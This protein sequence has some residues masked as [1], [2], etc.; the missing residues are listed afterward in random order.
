MNDVTRL[1]AVAAP[2]GTAVPYTERDAFELSLRQ[3]KVY[4]SADLVPQ[5][6][7]DNIP[8]CLIALNMARRIGSD[9]LQTMQS[10]Y[11]VQGKPGWSGQ[12]LIATFNQCGKFS[13]IRYQWK[14]EAGS[15][16]WGCRAYATEKATGDSIEGPWVT[17]KMV[18]AEGWN[19]KAG[20]KWLTMPEIMFSYRAAAFLVRTHAPEIAM[21]LAT[22]EE[23]RDVI[24][25]EPQPAKSATDAVLST[26]RGR[27]DKEAPHIDQE[28][29]TGPVPANLPPAVEVPQEAPPPFALDPDATQPLERPT[30]SYAAVR[31]QLDNAGN[32][33]ALDQAA[34]HI[35]LVDAGQRKEL[36]EYY[37]ARKAAL[38]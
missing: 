36:V 29:A 2:I 35:E 14:G 34:I 32:R 23:I 22:V 28:Q 33:D 20:S 19:K 24:D 27:L 7:R 17:W 6:Y 9:P 18:E 15:K 8:N 21:G 16:E 4:A 3:A 11:I 30:M 10:L 38:K 13:A 1:P 12:F 26:L 25:V 37:K 31:E 5:Q